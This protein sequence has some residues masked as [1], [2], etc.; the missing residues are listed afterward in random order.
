MK[1]YKKI[2]IVITGIAILVT[3]ILCKQEFFLMIPLFISLFV[4]AFQS[5]ANRLGSLM[6][7]MNSLLYA[8]CYIY[9]GGGLSHTAL[10]ICESNYVRFT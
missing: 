2:I 8:G 9:S 4:M 1:L 3:G 10:L 6:G 5:E 7:S